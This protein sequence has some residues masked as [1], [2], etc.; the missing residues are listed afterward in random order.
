MHLRLFSLK[1]QLQD[2]A[3]FSDAERLKAT[4]T[5]VKLLQRHFQADTLP[6]IQRM[7]QKEQEKV[8]RIVE[9]MEGKGCRVP[10]MKAEAELAE[11]LA[12]LTLQLKGSGAELTR[13]LQNLLAVSRVHANGTGGASAYLPGSTK[14]HEQSLADMREVLQQQTEAISRLGNVLK[15]DIRDTSIIMAEDTEMDEG[16]DSRAS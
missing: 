9:V 15:R 7:R 13:R 2:E 8:M 4:Q 14:I 1:R 5:N 12:A 16:N 11:K 10:L 6:S 3:I